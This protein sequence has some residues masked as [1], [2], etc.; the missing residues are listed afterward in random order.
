VKQLASELGPV[1]QEVL[2]SAASTLKENN[3]RIENG[4][5]IWTF[6]KIVFHFFLCRLA[7]IEK[8]P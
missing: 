7:V 2:L 1:L 8:H 4:K 3:E 6:G 5:C